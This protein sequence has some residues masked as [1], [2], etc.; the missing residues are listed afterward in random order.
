M[1][2]GDYVTIQEIKNQNVARWV[3]LTDLKF[4]NYGDYEGVNGGVV[5]Y[6]AETKSEAGD[7]WC[8]LPED[9]GETLLVCGALDELCVGGMIV[10]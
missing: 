7:V 3:V 10:E 9:D 5:H 8:E 1:Q 4:V 2:I 6:I